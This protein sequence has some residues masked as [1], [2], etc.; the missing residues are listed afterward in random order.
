MMLF[1]KKEITFDSFIRGVISLAICVCMFLLLERLSGVLLPFVTAW[2]IAYMLYPMVLFFQYKC[3]LRN[4][5][6]SIVVSL[7]V[8]LVA[9]AVLL[10]LVIPPFIEEFDKFLDLVSVF[11]QG[12]LADN[13]MV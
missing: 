3:R 1:S 7:L 5:V 11:M 13:G 2:L 10:G 6:L 4:R 8:V 9:F 12:S